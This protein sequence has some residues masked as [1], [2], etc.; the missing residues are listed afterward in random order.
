MKKIVIIG[1]NSFQNPL[2][3]KAKEMGYE[4]HVFAWAE[5]AIGEKTSDYF[6]PI[7][8]TEKEKI[9]G[10]CIKI[11]PVAIATIA[12]D[13]ANITV[14]YL[15]NKL[16]LI[17]NSEKSVLVSTNKYE[18]RKALKD[19]GIPTPGF[20]CVNK[21]NYL[22]CIQNIKFPIIVKPTDRSGSRGIT[23]VNSMKDLENAVNVATENSFENKAIIE[24]Y[25][26]GQEYSCE[27]ISYKGEHHF[28]AITKK[29]TTGSP[30]F[31]EI[32]H[33]QPSQLMLET[34]E[35]I[36]KQVFKALDALK[37]ENGPSHS[38][39]KV[40]NEGEIRIIEIGSRMGGDCI[41]SDLV[42][43]STGYDFLRMNLEVALGKEPTLSKTD[44]RKIAI[45]RF[46]FN[47]NDL[48]KLSM[49]K[50][51]YPENIY[52]ISDIKINNE[53][54]IV[55]SSSRFGYYILSCDDISI[56]DFLFEEEKR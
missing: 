32:G 53:I 46:I 6:Y 28:L 55:D 29:F 41:G 12:S 39:F 14:N 11:K 23:K 36:K 7:S 47:D 54:G 19:Y 4:T 48:S 9:L 31:I 34:E 5:G 17:T 45:I 56:L 30:N 33:L 22:D 16:G 20:A 21:L 2:I 26:E 15:C 3:M 37:I 51:N 38:E 35:K 1:A 13:L 10:E 8:I 42:K 27:C 40:N 49:I 25:I 52:F 43:I 50:N 24:E 18:M 44:D